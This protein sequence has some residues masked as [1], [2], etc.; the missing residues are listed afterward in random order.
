MVGIP[1]G[2]R[3]L[4]RQEV[5][6]DSPK[7]TSVDIGIIRCLHR[8][9]RQSFVKIAAELKVPE[10]TVRHRL[11]RLMRHG[12]VEF[13]AVTNPLRMG[14]QSWA[15]VEIQGQ[16]S[17]IRAIAEELAKVPEVYFVG[18]TTGEYDILVN[19]VFPS[20]AELLHFLTT[21]L[22]KIRGV[23]RTATSTLLDVVKRRLTLDFPDP[24]TNGSA[25]TKTPSRRKT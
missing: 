16:P 15:I 13:S 17:R 12:I 21:R 18:I 3:N 4:T 9:A 25:V 8:D 6:M 11:N 19:A 7:I 23:T 10:S 2:Q 1:R 24:T 20:N 14:Y 22:S 5:A